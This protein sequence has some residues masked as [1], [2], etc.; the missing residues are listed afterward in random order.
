VEDFRYGQK[1]HLTAV[2]RIRKNPADDRKT[3]D[4]FCI[5]P[6]QRAHRTVRHRL[7]EY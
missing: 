2:L 3:A 4:G 5:S 1:N 6:R 7:G